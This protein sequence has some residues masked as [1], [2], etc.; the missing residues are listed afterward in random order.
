FASPAPRG[1]ASCGEARAQ[2]RRPPP[3][4]AGDDPERTELADARTVRAMASEGHVEM[5]LVR[6]GGDRGALVPGA[7]MP[8]VAGAGEEVGEVVAGSV[9]DLHAP[10]RQAVVREM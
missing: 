2:L 1:R 5:H 4:E 6:G 9:P 10:A 7:V 3:V 8:A